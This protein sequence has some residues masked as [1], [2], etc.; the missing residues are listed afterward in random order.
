MRRPLR[1]AATPRRTTSSVTRLRVPIS[2]SAPQR[3]QLLTLRASSWNSAG[4][5]MVGTLH[6]EREDLVGVDAR[7]DG[8]Q[9]VEP[10]LE[11]RSLQWHV[12]VQHRLAELPTRV[13]FH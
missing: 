6:L 3:P 11:L 13:V 5:P 9:V 4:M 10:G 8:V 1:A 2:S 7:A 12:V